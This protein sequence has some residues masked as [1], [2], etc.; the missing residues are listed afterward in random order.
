MQ[1][2]MERIRLKKEDR[3]NLTRQRVCCCTDYEILRIKMSESQLNHVCLN[4]VV[5]GK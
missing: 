1:E 2:A 3:G 5:A 4:Y